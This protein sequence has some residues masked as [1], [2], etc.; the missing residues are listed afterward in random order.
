MQKLLKRKHKPWPVTAPPEGVSVNFFP[1]LSQW[2]CGKNVL[3]KAEV[4]EDDTSLNC[5]TE[6]LLLVCCYLQLRVH[7]TRE[8]TLIS[9]DNG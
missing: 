1:T 7:V 2:N 6:I 8:N 5:A 9:E 3:N 4:L